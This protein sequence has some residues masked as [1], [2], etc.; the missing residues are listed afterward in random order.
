MAYAEAVPSWF[1]LKLKVVQPG[2]GALECNLTGRYP[3][4]KNLTTRLGKRIAFPYP[5]SE[6]VRLQKIPKTI[7]KTIVYCSRK[8]KPVVLEQIVM[9]CFG[10][11]DQFSY[12]LQEFMQKHDTLKNAHVPYWFMWKCPPGVQL[13]RNRV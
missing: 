5:V 8:Q 4:F 6:F 10:V 11:S 12:P 7:G 1:P 9:T 2:G 13:R 3:F